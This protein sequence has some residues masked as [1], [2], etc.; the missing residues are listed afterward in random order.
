MF[1]KRLTDLSRDDLQRLVDEEV[2]EGAEV[3]FKQTLPSKHGNVD[4]WLAGGSSVGERARNELIEELIA[5]ANSYGGTLLL[6][7]A[8]TQSKPPRASAIVPVPRCTELAE[9]LKLQCRDCIEPQIPLLEIVGIETELDGSGVVVFSAP[10]SRMAPHRHIPLRECYVRRADR[11]EKM[12][13]R[14]IQDLT[15]L[16]SHGLQAIEK[17]FSAQSEKFNQA[18]D[19]YSGPHTPGAYG[20]RATLVPLTPLY[21][22]RVHNNCDVQPRLK[23]LPATWG[24]CEV[25]VSFPATLFP[26]RPILRGT[27]G[28][29]KADEF[30]VAAEVHCDGMIEYTLLCMNH[31]PWCLYPEW[32][33]ALVVNALITSERF[34]Q[35]VGIPDVEFGMDVEILVW[36]NALAVDSFKHRGGYLGELPVG[37]VAFPRYSVGSLPEMSDVTALFFQDYLHASGRD[38]ADKL[39]VNY[40]EALKSFQD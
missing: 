39:V 29:S 34:R 18:F 14:E 10:Q 25:N 3:E 1:A 38:T 22:S 35:A 2:P 21:I 28:E 16:V 23:E 27:R 30:Q 40:A 12:T 36:G 8:E 26:F 17:K 37:S 32:L 24:A 15:L 7:I 11:S 33:M 20:I 19:N 5:F 31:Q 9:R 6:G 4:P 13:M